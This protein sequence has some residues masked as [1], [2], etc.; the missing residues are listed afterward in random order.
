MTK[1]TCDGGFVPGKLDFHNPLYLSVLGSLDL[2]TEIQLPKH[3]STDPMIFLWYCLVSCMTCFSLFQ[4]QIRGKPQRKSFLRLTCYVEEQLV[5]YTRS[6]AILNV[7]WCQRTGERRFGVIWKLTSEAF[8]KEQECLYTSTTRLPGMKSV[9]NMAC[10]HSS[11]MPHRRPLSGCDRYMSKHITSS[12][13]E[14]G[15]Y[16]VAAGSTLQLAFPLLAHFAVYFQDKPEHS[17]FH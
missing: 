2:P 7:G 10:F 11:S 12:L 4:P 13:F 8:V 6:I 5:T 9:P 1:Q 15:P 17:A 16:Y 14:L 3:T